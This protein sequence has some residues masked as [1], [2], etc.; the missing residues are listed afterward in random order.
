VLK[1]KLAIISRYRSHKRDI[2]LFLIPQL[3]LLALYIAKLIAGASFNAH[4][5]GNSNVM[6]SL[7]GYMLE[8]DLI[9]SL[10]GMHT[11]PPLLNFVFGLAILASNTH[12]HLIIQILWLFVAQIGV[13]FLTLGIKAIT[14]NRFLTASLTVLYIF[15]P[16]TVMYSLW[17]YNTIWVQSFSI[18]L[19][20]SFIRLLMKKTPLF[21]FFC[22]AI[23]SIVLYLIR[24]PFNF[25]LTIFFIS[26]SWMILD[27]FLRKRISVVLIA[28][29]S[30][31]CICAIQAHYY[32]N[33]GLLST[34][35][36][37]L[38]QSIGVL[39]KGLLESELSLIAEVSPCFS[40]VIQK[41]PWMPIESYDDCRSRDGI[42]ASN[43]F[44]VSSEKANELNSRSRLLG[45][46]AIEKV[47]FYTAPKYPQAYLRVIF[48]GPRF[49]GTLFSYLGL[50][51]FP[52]TPVKFLVYNVIPLLFFISFLL[53]CTLLVLGKKLYLA[54]LKVLAM[55]VALTFFMNLYALIGE[56][57]ENE[58]IRSDSHAVTFFTGIILLAYCKKLSLNKKVIHNS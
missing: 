51:N 8:S 54:E 46:L 16:G 41:G 9:G 23:S 26:I 3:F 56:V 6:Q 19:L 31:S 50:K 58:R 33:F 22:L 35:S 45:S 52:F 34:S 18:I 37:T 10:K 44:F 40:D 36:W 32:F 28:S 14:S 15:V 20:S 27:K 49:D 47:L 55:P 25:V 48:G 2:I 42:I 53:L 43:E 29:V 39:K 13:F 17:S 1:N 57:V 24:V 38:D 7:N 30:I 12:A 5:I 4:F 11:Q 21:S